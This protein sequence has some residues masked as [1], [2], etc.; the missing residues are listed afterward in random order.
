MSISLTNAPADTFKHTDRSTG[1]E[2]VAGPPWHIH[3]VIAAS[4]ILLFIGS[5]LRHHAFRSGALDLG[6]FDQ[7]TYL[8]SRGEAPINS[9][10]NFHLLSDHAAYT[11][12]LL[13]PLYWIWPNV[14]VL[15]LVQAIALA[16]GAYPVYRIAQLHGLS[17]RHALALAVAY[18]L[19]P[20][21][22]S[23]NLFDFHPE[24][25]S[26]AALLFAV[27][28]AMR[29]SIVAFVLLIALAL[30]GKE[31]ISLTVCAM[32]VWL[33]L[34]ERRLLQGL[35]AIVMGASWFVFATR[36]LIPHFGAGKNAS[37]MQFFSYLGGSVGEIAKNLVLQP[38]RWFKI[39]F[40]IST[41]KY[42]FILFAPVAWGL[43]PRH[44]RSF[45]YLAP[46]I[47][48]AAPTL[49]LNILAQSS[50][51]NLR[52]PFGQYSLMVVPFLAITFVY[53]VA[54]GQSWF[55]RPYQIAIWSIGLVLIGATARLAMVQRGQATDVASQLA[56]REAV[57]MIAGKGGVLTT[58]EIAPH[59]SQRKLIQY[60][61]NEFPIAPLDQFDYVFL[62]LK[63][64]SLVNAGTFTTSVLDRVRADPSFKLEFDRD[65]VLLFKNTAAAR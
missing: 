3:A 41:M 54:A 17:H 65:S 42:L 56:T 61:G 11:L 7:L 52:K 24:V 5:A 31:V 38:Q 13:A 12:Y 1:A 49:A 43:V 44:R 19:Y 51:V 32:G 37:G 18:L 58:F 8:I 39:V 48:C 35:I 33:I 63:H 29:R 57:A 26:V 27:L 21:V 28:A 55:K 2:F 62:N 9:I 6:F 59:V 34:F 50:V 47:V 45:R 64:D 10:A 14:Q 4:S 16:S 36:W 15:L 60:V 53:A 22:L 25:I 46:L 20:I 30:G 40:T 23:A